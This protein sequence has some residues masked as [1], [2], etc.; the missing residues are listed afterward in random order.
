M[1]SAEVDHHIAEQAAGDDPATDK[2]NG[3][4]SKTV[5]SDFGKVKINTPRDRNGSFE[6]QQV[7]KRARKLS[8]GLD[9]QIIAL[10]AQGNSVEN[11]RRLIKKLYSV[12][13][14]AGQISTITEQVWEDLS[15]WRTRRIQCAYAVT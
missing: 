13:L 5:T 4:T 8:T 14:S 15:A 1:L 7:G 3:Y 11:V 10:Y 9:Q 12:E 2:R 6:P